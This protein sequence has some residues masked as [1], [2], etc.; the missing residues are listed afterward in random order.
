MSPLASC[1]CLLECVVSSTSTLAMQGGRRHQVAYSRAIQKAAAA[2]QLRYKPVLF[3]LCSLPWQVARWFWPSVCAL[4]PIFKLL[5]SRLLWCLVAVLEHYLPIHCI[6]CQPYQ[7]PQGVFTFI[8]HSQ[9]I[10]DII[11]YVQYALVTK[12]SITHLILRASA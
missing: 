10:A 7:S 9:L 12:V 8:Q 2:N 6:K 3:V 5:L 1:C 11:W 4:Y